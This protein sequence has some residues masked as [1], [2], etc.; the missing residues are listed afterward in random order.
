MVPRFIAKKETVDEPATVQDTAPV[1]TAKTANHRLAGG[2]YIKLQVY[3]VWVMLS[4][5]ASDYDHY[6]SL[7]T[8]IIVLLAKNPYPSVHRSAHAISLLDL[9]CSNSLFMKS[10]EMFRELTK[11]LDVDALE[12]AVEVYSSLIWCYHYYY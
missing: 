12:T 2:G 1:I 5:T 6:Y 7:R 8:V 3:T 9:A 10:Y 11:R 4:F